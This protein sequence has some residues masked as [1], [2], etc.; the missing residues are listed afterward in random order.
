MA[1]APQTLIKT[2][3]MSSAMNCLPS[4]SCLALLSSNIETRRVSGERDRQRG[5]ERE[6]ERERA[7][8]RGT[9]RGRG[10]GRGQ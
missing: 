5:R 7:E 3:F 8:I 2:D 6:R 4:H 10:R 9:I 1:A